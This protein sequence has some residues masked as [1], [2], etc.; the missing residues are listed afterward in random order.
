MIIKTVSCGNSKFTI[1]PHFHLLNKSF[2]YNCKIVK[3]VA[4]VDKIEKKNRV[5]SESMD[6]SAVKQK[7]WREKMSYSEIVDIFLHVITNFLYSFVMQRKRIFKVWKI[8]EHFPYWCD[9]AA[10]NY[11]LFLG[12]KNLLRRRMT[13]YLMNFIKTCN[14][15][16]NENDTGANHLWQNFVRSLLTK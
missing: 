11:C 2:C 16:V 4:F 1:L 9:L 14:R 10:S 15:F 7:K 12:L 13:M 5:Y 8:Y 6:P 3:L